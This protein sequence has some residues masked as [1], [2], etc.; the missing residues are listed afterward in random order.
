[1]GAEGFA[2][3][4]LDEALCGVLAELGYEEPTP[5]QQAAI[6]MLLEGR[7]VLAQAATGTGKTAA[8]SLPLLSRVRAPG[9]GPAGSPSLLVVAP[10]REL[11]VQVAEA[12]ERYGRAAGVTVIAV[13]GGQDIVRQLKPLRRPV[14]V[15]VATPGR[16]IDHLRRGTLKLDRV[17]AVVLDEADEMLDMG[18]AEEL[19]AILEALPEKRQTALFSATL[20]S[21]IA[22]LAEKHLSNPARIQIKPRAATAGSLP[23]IRQTAYVVPKRFKELTLSRV[24][25]LEAPHS[26]ILFCRTRLE[27]DRLAEVLMRDGH[28]VAALHG[29]LTQEQRDRVL[30]RF[31]AE[32]IRMLIATDVAARGLDVEHLS[33]VVNY[34]LPT[35]PEPYVHRIGRTGRA[36][37]EGVAISLLDTRELRLLRNV[38]RVTGQ[39]VEIATPPS[40]A[41]LREHRIAKMRASVAERLR[42]EPA[43][44]VWAAVRELSAQAGHEQLAAAALSALLELRHPGH[45]DDDVE[46]PPPSARALAGPPTEK[47]R[48]L[49]GQRTREGGAGPSKRERWSTRDGEPSGPRDRSGP[50]APKGRRNMGPT[51]RLFV[52]LGETAGLRPGDLVG[53]LANEGGLSPKD[54]GAIEIFP[55]HAFVELSTGVVDEMQ[56]VLRGATLR[57]RKVKVE[58]DRGT[59][60][61]RQAGE[62]PRSPRP[63]AP[64]G[65]PKGPRKPRTFRGE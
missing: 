63:F 34:D 54:I 25:E 26:A 35:S 42:S 52:G 57:G 41:Q 55:H 59:G 48:R 36:G 50:G 46:I 6:P 51:T 10:T 11:A 9:K 60:R 33:H 27:V 15:V 28:A 18:F 64:K 22:K 61:P 47:Q 16:A 39:P 13:Y 14:D 43:A 29:G 45:E 3:L 5:V 20:P 24:L 1:V 58:R 32:K 37:R 31:K 53:A 56:E 21:R 40:P 17:Q 30:Q 38:E 7:D 8:F 44:D 65:G 12:I 49:E 19:E 23:K 4:G 62:G 2:A